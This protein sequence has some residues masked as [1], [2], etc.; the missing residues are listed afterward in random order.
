MNSA[1][2]PTSKD[3]FISYASRDWERVAPI[4]D[5]LESAGISMWRDQNEILGGEC[6]GSAIVHAI[7]NSKVL[8]L[9]CSNAS[10]RSK[11][12][13][14][15]IRLAWKYG[16][17]YLP[18]LLEVI[19]FPEQVEYWLEGNQWIEIL[20]HPQPAWVPLVMRALER[21]GIYGQSA[22]DTAGDMEPSQSPIRL[23]Q[24]LEGLW[25]AAK[26]TDQ[27]WPVP[28]NTVERN[29]RRGVT[30][31]LGAPQ[32]EVSHGFRL[33]SRVRV[34]I[35]SQQEG[36]LL[37]LD[38]GP[39]GTIY[40][41]CPSLFVPDTRLAIG[42]TVLPQPQSRYDSFLVTGRPGREQLL[43]ILTT[44]PLKIDWMPPD[45]SVPARTLSRLDV[46]ELISELKELD[47]DHWLALATYFDVTAA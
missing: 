2:I 45:H 44:E 35:E 4:M 20:D 29:V 22:P 23:E 10:L 12:V 28:A 47:A 43:A 6:Y 21:I 30:R 16:V 3:V 14:Q 9:M 46:D 18:L 42:Q 40:C 41:L 39:E 17:P 1:S 34:I 13:N 15:E 26:F 24:G 36:H 27:I 37:L 7:Q 25:L 8:I 33:G 19:S 38:E 32:S 5:A 11:D 31:G